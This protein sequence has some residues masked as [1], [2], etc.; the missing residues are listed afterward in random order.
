V[1]NE[2]GF[3]QP[4]P[5]YAGLVRSIISGL[6]LVSLGSLGSLGSLSFG[7]AHHSGGDNGDKQDAGILA[8]DAFA[9]PYSDF[10]T[11]PIVDTSGA[12]IVPGD[13]AT[14]FGGAGTGAAAGGPCMFEPEI[15]TIY[16]RNW[17][18]PRFSWI[19]GAGES[20][21]ELRI[22]SPSQV[23]AMIVYTTSTVWTMPPAIWET[24]R[25]HSV[26]SPL[27]VT[28]RG[29]ASDQTTVTTIA[30]GS[31]GD[32][33]IAPVD[34]PGAI[35]YWTTTNARLRGF[36]IGDETV[37]DIITPSQ[38]ATAA[39][40]TGAKCIGCHSSTPDGT[41]VGFSSSQQAGTGDPTMLGLLTTDG[42]PVA[43]PFLTPAAIAMMQ[44]LNQEEPVF[45]KLHWANGDHAAVTMYPVNGKFE[46]MWTDLEATSTAQGQ[47][48]DIIA[49]TGEAN[50]AASASFAH[51]TDTLLYVSS[52]HV[53][54]GV[55]V[56]H[57]DLM[58]VPYNSHAG[59]TPTAIDGANTTAYNEYYPTFSPDDTYV[60]YNRVADGQSSYNNSQAEVFV[61]KGAGG[62]PTRLA[63]NDPPSCG[64]RT[65]PGVTNSWPKWAPGASDVA[66]HRYYWLT[67]SSTRGAAGNPQLYVTPVIDDGATLR[68]YPALYLWNQPAA[69]NNHTPAWDN[70][71]I[72][73]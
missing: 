70:F 21:Y 18:R 57:G 16:P 34:A 3:L 26:S 46:M 7:C 23:N 11:D 20:I 5:A 22:T 4:S 66:G 28:V 72:L 39:S 42:A 17:I 47:G 27:T 45:S 24:L 38:A 53:S 62:T 71:G 30:V 31:T 10:P 50:P 25:V 54:S 32:V 40:S 35:V 33:Q 19:A 1:T 58:T 29:A 65:S 64:A 59:G 6:A 43:P 63:A 48:W 67:F 41:Y 14:Q 2:K 73:E 36:K 44:R 49:R 51:T 56:D 68:T 13:V 52:L 8:P 69:E 60:A 15:G 37:K 55:S 61:V 12:T 9:G